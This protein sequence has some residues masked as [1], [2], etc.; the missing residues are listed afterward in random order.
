MYSIQ[1]DI[2]L[3][4][5]FRFAALRRKIQIKTETYFVY[6]NKKWVVFNEKSGKR[7]FPTFSSA[8]GNVYWYLVATSHLGLTP[9]VSFTY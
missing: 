7:L 1:T 3:Q 2:F 8:Q 9:K 5:N 4:F 6:Q